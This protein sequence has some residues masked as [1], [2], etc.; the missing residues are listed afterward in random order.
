MI[1][2]ASAIYV[3]TRLR[4]GSKSFQSFSNL[5]NL[6][7]AMTHSGRGNDESTVSDERMRTKCYGS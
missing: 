5:T 6:M 7:V 2:A 3:R 4:L 1:C